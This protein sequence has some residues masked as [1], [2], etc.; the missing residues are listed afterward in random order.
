MA[1]TT[2]IAWTDHTFNPWMGCTKV[3]AGCANCYA[4]TLS[5]NRMG[6]DIW[7]PNAP[8][9]ITKAPWNIVRAWEKAAAAGHPG[10][11]DNGHHL[12]FTGS[13]MDWAEDRP[14]LVEPRTRM[15]RTIRECPHLWFQLLTKRPENIVGFLPEDW[16]QGYD[17]VWLGTSIEDMR[18]AGRADHLRGIQAPVRFISYE[19]ALGSLNDLDLTGIDWVIFGGESGSGYRAM[20]VQW[21]LDMRKKCEEGGIA[22][23]FKQS[24]ATRTE[25]GIELAGEIVRKFPTPRLEGNMLVPMAAKPS[26]GAAQVEREGGAC[27][28]LRDIPHTHLGDH[29]TL[30]E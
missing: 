2:I 15:W 7:G 19:P 18:V 25:K 17:N 4:K 27:S 20:D 9:Q 24:A 16:G 6:L 21:A 10:L 28:V 5:K 11:L 23:F 1:D 29:A 3:S 13:M 22:F 30:G 14:D 26:V 12:V 8:R